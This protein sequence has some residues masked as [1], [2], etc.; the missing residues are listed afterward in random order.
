MPA[1]KLETSC[2]DS[3]SGCSVLLYT[4]RRLGCRKIRSRMVAR[5][6]RWRCPA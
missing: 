6:R 3:L 1:R 2:S 4:D 5:A